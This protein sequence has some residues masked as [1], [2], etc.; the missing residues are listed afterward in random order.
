MP[1]RVDEAI[2]K[3]LG[4]RIERLGEKNATAIKRKENEDG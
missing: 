3:V 1:Q 2:R 4:V